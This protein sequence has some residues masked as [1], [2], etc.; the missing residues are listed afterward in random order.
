MPDFWRASGFELLRRDSAG[1][2]AVTEGFLHAYL[3]RPEVRPSDESCP[4][5]LALH[6]ALMDDPARTVTEADIAALA[7]PDARE[8]WRLLIAFRDRLLAAGSVEACYLALFRGAT[9]AIAPLFVDQMAHVVLRNALDGCDDAF[10]ARAGELFFRSQKATLADGAI[11]LA[12]EETVEFHRAGAEFGTLGRLIAEAATPLAAFELDVLVPQNAALYWDRSDR[13]DMVLDAS[14]GRPGLDGLCRAIAAWIRHFL[15]VE[16]SVQPVMHIRDRHWA[17]HIG[18]DAEATAI[19]NDLYR[20][21]EIEEDRMRRL[22]A[23]FR[24]EFRDPRAMRADIAGRPVY[25][26]LATNPAGRVRIKPQNLLVNLPVA[27]R[28]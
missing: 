18:L 8:N 25:L 1:W 15:A 9:V 4:A 14:F 10:A 2:L 19:L 20:G 27:A 13:Y 23:L 24:L 7:D 3:L 11:M 12:D 21:A 16:I 26:G 17:W 5:E 22:L 28:V 6:A